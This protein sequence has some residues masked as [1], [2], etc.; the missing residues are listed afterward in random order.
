MLATSKIANGQSLMKLRSLKTAKLI[1]VQVNGKVRAK[2]TVAAD[3]DKESVEAL[4]MSDEH[5]IKY[6]TA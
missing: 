5:V 3:A 4:G 6:Q 2:I 1:V